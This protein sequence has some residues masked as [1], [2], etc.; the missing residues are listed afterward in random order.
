MLGAASSGAP[1]LSEGGAVAWK[2]LSSLCGVSTEE[3]EA[4]AAAAQARGPLRAQL[5]VSM[6]R[7]ILDADA[8]VIVGAAR[9]VDASLRSSAGHGSMEGARKSACFVLSSSGAAGAQGQQV[10]CVWSPQAS[11]QWAAF[12]GVHDRAARRAGPWDGETLCGAAA[13]DL[14]T[15]SS[16]SGRSGLLATLQAQGADS[17]YGGESA[18]ESSRSACSGAD[19][20]VRAAEAPDK[21]CQMSQATALAH[22]HEG[23]HR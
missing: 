4:L 6:E 12:A 19:G 2:A 22:Y 5:G 8:D 13:G 14:A 3:E 9:S 7:R 23:M 15:H 21:G 18:Y 11:A 20:T 17:G 16:S 10:D 1:R